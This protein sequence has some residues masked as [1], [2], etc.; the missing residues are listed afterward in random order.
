MA[1]AKPADSLEV[2]D[3]S[4]HPVWRFVIDDS[5]GETTV[6]PVKRL[7][8]RSL[9]NKLIG[10]QVRLANGTRVWALITNVDLNDARMNQQFLEIAV[11]RN[12]EKF[13]LA[14]YHDVDYESRGPDALA[15][16]LHLPVDDVFPIFY[17]LRPVVA[18]NPIILAG[19]I[20][21]QP[22]EILSEQER[23]RMIV[24]NV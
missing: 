11:F 23:M 5:R 9:T 8:V 20:T 15:A 10:V 24:D 6:V 1:S 4:Q 17:D 3:L 19:S 18:G 13:W 22:L 7:P 14:R 16:F 2:A 12:T 21:R